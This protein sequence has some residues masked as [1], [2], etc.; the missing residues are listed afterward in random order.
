MKPTGEIGAAA[1]RRAEAHL[2]AHGLT[3]RERNWRCR[4]GEIDLIMQEGGELVFVEVR[5]RSSRA[6][7]GAAASVAARKQQRLCRAAQLYLQQHY[8]EAGRPPPNCRFDVVSIDHGTRPP[9]LDWL[10]G[11][12]DGSEH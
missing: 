9:G 3:L 8:D 2:A 5:A 6:F 11:A 7:G 1:E 10:R 4:F 12:F